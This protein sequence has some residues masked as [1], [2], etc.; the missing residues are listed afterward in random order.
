MGLDLLGDVGQVLLAELGLDRLEVTDRVDAVVDVDDLL[1]VERADAVVDAVDG[2]DVGQERVP[3]ARA[4]GRALDEPRDVRHQELRRHLG[5]RL[6]EVAEPLEPLVRH[7]ALRLVGVD[8]TWKE[9][10]KE[11]ARVT[12]AQP[13]PDDGDRGAARRAAATGDGGRRATRRRESSPP[14]RPGPSGG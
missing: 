10:R 8:G 13:L 4:L 3:E 14:P 9:G 11:D 12:E 6:V 7:G 2:L 5:R 1:R